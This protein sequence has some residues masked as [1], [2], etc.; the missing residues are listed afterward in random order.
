MSTATPQD[1]SPIPAD[2]PAAVRIG[3][4]AEAQQERKSFLE[5]HPLAEPKAALSVTPHSSEEETSATAGATQDVLQ[6]AEFATTLSGE[7]GT[8][9]GTSATAGA[10]RD[11][12][13]DKAEAIAA[14]VKILLT[15]SAE[16][17]TVAVETMCALA[18]DDDNHRAIASAGTAEISFQIIRIL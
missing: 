6:E 11:I 1:H 16:E 4:E 7:E 18:N 8:S 14:L 5:A 3:A 13:S 17:K 12:L 9:A 2:D 15:G 10:T